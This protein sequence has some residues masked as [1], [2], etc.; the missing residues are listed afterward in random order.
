MDYGF[1][2]A[3]GSLTAYLD[4]YII[5]HRTESYYAKKEKEYWNLWKKDAK[6]IFS[7]VFIF[8]VIHDNRIYSIIMHNI[9]TNK[10]EDLE[11]LEFPKLWQVPQ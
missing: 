11:D 5:E 3:R 1:I 2:L 8:I 9:G 6:I 7:L 10:G 4:L